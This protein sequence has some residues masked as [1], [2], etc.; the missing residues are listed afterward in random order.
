MTFRTLLLGTAL[1]AAIPAAALAETTQGF[2]FG[3]QV[4]AS[5]LEDTKYNGPVTN[6]A[7]FKTAISSVVELGYQ[8]D[9]GL[10]FGVEGGY[11][12]HT[13]G[14]IV[15]GV[16]GRS[17]G[18]GSTSALTLMGVAAYS[19]DTGTPLSP[20][21]GGGVGV[22]RIGLRDA[23]ALFS[24]NQFADE[25]DTTVAYQL[26]AGL[27]YS[28]LSNMDATLSYRYLRAEPVKMATTTGNNFEF[29]YDNHSVLVGIRVLFGAPTRT[30]APTPAPQPVVQQPA[31]VAQPAVAAP[32]ISRNFTVF[33]D[34]NKSTLTADAEQ[35]LRNVARDA[36]TGKVAAVQVT[37]YTDTSGSPTYNQKLSEARA[38]AVRE[39]LVSQG[40]TADQIATAGRGE[41]ELLVPTADNVREPSNRR[42]V[43]LFP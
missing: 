21:F 25:K 33:F 10:R 26:N 40:L 6:K 5:W 12:V 9:N 13:I 3:S 19:I 35:V 22:A 42:A 34:W 23:G 11:G 8:L 28:I 20:F 2:Y 18:N 17:G 31:P 1:A 36:M 38:A 4:G 43:I 15:G 30:V 29:D 37:G 24:A 16:A 7:D 39:F 41:T 14:D 32:T 27:N